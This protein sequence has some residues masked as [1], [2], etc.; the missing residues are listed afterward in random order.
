MEG[1]LPHGRARPGTL[2][3]SRVTAA[4]ARRF[5]LDNTAVMAPPHVPEIRLHLADEAHELWHR[6][7]E[8]LADVGGDGVLALELAD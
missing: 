8:E 6:T 1:S 4:S 3:G 5:I 7:E 2:S